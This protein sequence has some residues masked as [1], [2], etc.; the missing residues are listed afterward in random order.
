VFSQAD[1]LGKGDKHNEKF[2][3]WEY[4]IPLHDSSIKSRN[5]SQCFFSFHVYPTDE[6]ESTYHST[7]PEVVTVVLVTSFFFVLSTFAVY[8]RCVAR[9]SNKVLFEVSRSQAI[10]STMFPSNVQDRLF[11]DGPAS[12]NSRG[13]LGNKSRLKN[14][15]AAGEEND[16]FNS[17]PIADLFL[18]TTVLF[19]DVVGFTA[20]SSTREPSQVCAYVK[21]RVYYAHVA[22]KLV[23]FERF[24]LSWRLC[25]QLLMPSLVN[26]A[27]S[28]L[29]LLGIATLPFQVC[30]IRGETTL[31]LWQD[32]REIASA[33][34]VK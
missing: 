22:D 25:L 7:T 34:S 33:N 3:Q 14:F 15:L 8:D 19:A 28:K 30:P 32:L 13:K 21:N 20:W 2:S 1:F 5:D 27:F 26:A 16:F 12:L 6:F 23:N 29:R 24:F 17:K 11:S 18:E 10:V 31:L 9:F 4:V